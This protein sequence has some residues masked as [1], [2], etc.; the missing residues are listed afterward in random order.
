MS[1]LTIAAQYGHVQIV[2]TLLE[3]GAHVD[4]L[5][6]FVSRSLSCSRFPVHELVVMTG[7][8]L[9]LKL[10]YRCF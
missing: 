1:A 7:Q 8:T 9:F 3:Y 5:D 10:T 6:E 4:L 2:N